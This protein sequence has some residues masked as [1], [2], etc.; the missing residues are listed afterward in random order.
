MILNNRT[1]PISRKK[2]YGIIFAHADLPKAFQ[3]TLKT[4]FGKLPNFAFITNSGLSAETLV[5]R[6]EKRLL[7]LGRRSVFLFVD[8]TG[9]S[10]WHIC[11]P[12]KKKFK[13]IEII[14]GF[15]LPMLVKFIQYREKVEPAELL[16][17]IIAAGKETIKKMEE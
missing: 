3:K 2:V 4:F 17:L 13:N 16:S 11:Y 14:A 5:R 6:L 15:N 8:M 7:R 9:S 1:T 10:C 12:L